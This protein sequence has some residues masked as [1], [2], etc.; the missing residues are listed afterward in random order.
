MSKTLKIGNVVIGGANKIAVQTMTTFKPRQIDETL[1][2]IN[3]A[4][5]AGCDIIRTSVTCDE[6]IVALG[7]IKKQINIP[8]VADIHFDY[9]LA[10][11]AIDVGVDKIRI[12]PGNIGNDANVKAVAEALK[13]NDVAVRVGANSGSI[14]KDFLN[15]Y[16]RSEVAL[17]ESALKNVSVLEQYGVDKIVISDQMFLKTAVETLKVKN[18]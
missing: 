1:L 2:Q 11:K 5:N 9:R 13:S 18:K 14:E 12:N 16:G 8:I 7:Q 10:I 6:D 4:V 3:N 15:K 17:V